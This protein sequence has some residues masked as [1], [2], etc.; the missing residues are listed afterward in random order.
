MLLMLRNQTNK[1]GVALCKEQKYD[2]DEIQI[3]YTDIS[4]PPLYFHNQQ[5]STKITAQ[6]TFRQLEY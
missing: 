3:H 6:V 2:S 5:F 4:L 1:K